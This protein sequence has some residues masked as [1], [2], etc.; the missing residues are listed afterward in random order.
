MLILLNGSVKSILTSKTHEEKLSDKLLFDHGLISYFAQL[1]QKDEYKESFATRKNIFPFIHN[2]TAFI[3]DFINQQHS[4]GE[5]LR[6]KLQSKCKND[7]NVLI[8]ALEDCE[9]IFAVEWGQMTEL[10]DPNRPPAERKFTVKEHAQ[11]GVE[12]NLMMST[13]AST[14]T[15]KIV[16]NSIASRK[17]MAQF[18][19]VLQ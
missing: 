14:T 12:Q 8:M 17:K 6:I 15:K 19:S 4:R 16:E 7:W 11:E 3:I 10:H 13:A 2:L 9:K 5:S 18:D 1:L